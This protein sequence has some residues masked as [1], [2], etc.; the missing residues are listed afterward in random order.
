M[1]NPNHLPETTPDLLPVVSDDAVELFTFRPPSFSEMQLRMQQRN[2]RLARYLL[3]RAQ[4]LAP[5]ERDIHAKEK[6]ARLAIEMYTLLESQGE[7]NLLDTEFTAD[8]P[9]PPG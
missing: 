8:A 4:E 1:V 9:L 6:V 5:G 7:V 2:P 3:S